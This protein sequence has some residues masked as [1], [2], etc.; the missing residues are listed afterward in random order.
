MPTEALDI[1]QSD[2]LVTYLREAGRIA[3][4]EPVG[5]RVLAGGVSNKT[6]LVERPSGE[7]WVLKQALPKLRV[8]VDWFSD[9]ARIGREALGLRYL[10]E[11]APPGTVTPLVFEDPAHHLLAM[12]AVPQPHENWKTMLMRGDVSMSHVEQFA[13]LLGAIHRRAAESAEPLSELFAD[14]RFFESL[15]VEPY[16]AYT[17]MQVPSASEFLRDLIDA[18]RSRRLT[19]VHGDFS[20]K[21]VLVHQGRLVLLDHEVIHWGDPAFDLGFALTHLL[22]KAHHCSPHSHRFAEAV[23]L[24]RETYRAVVGPVHWTDNLE[25]F[26]VHHTLGCLLA[27]VAGRSPL[28][29]LGQRERERQRDVVVRLMTVAPPTIEDLLRLFLWGIGAHAQ[30]Q[31]SFSP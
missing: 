7:A 10:A 6:V 9:P 17:A 27:R 1:E 18:T 30:G 15:R 16:Y 31:K 4:N 13:G 26:A 22:S 20:P 24:F 11:L 19:L 12:Q 29:Y 5:T 2:Q 8:A 28:E 14:R 23:L 3:P 21:N 25:A